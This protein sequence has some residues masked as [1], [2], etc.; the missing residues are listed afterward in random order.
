MVHPSRCGGVFF[1]VLLMSLFKSEEP[2]KLESELLVA[3]IQQKGTI[4]TG[5]SVLGGTYPAERNHQ[6]W[7]LTS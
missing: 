7:N 1:G 4:K 2:L 5:I 6:N 3:L